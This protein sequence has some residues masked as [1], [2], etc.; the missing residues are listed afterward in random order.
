VPCSGARTSAQ[1]AIGGRHSRIGSGSSAGPCSGYDIDTLTAV[2]LDGALRRQG[3][4][5]R[6]VLARNLEIALPRRGGRELAGVPRLGA[7]DTGATAGDDTGCI[8]ALAVR[9]R[10]AFAA[11]DVDT[12]MQ[13]HPPGNHSLVS[14][15]TAPHQQAGWQDYKKVWQERFAASPG[16]ITYSL[17]DRSVAVAGLVAYRQ[18]IEQEHSDAQGWIEDGPGCSRDGHLPNAKGS[19]A[20]R[21]GTCVGAGRSRDSK[22]G[23]PV[24]AAAPRAGGRAA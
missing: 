2:E 22:A 6:V 17:S 23:S 24:A 9:C 11:K 21:A 18:S 19:M 13:A 4:R 16:P 14:D 7:A 5:Q 8:E 10:A 15:V 3:P 1:R 20:G 12:W